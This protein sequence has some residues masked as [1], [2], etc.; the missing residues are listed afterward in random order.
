[1][2]RRASLSITMAGIAVVTLTLI[3]IF[4]GSTS[5]EPSQ[6]WQVL[7]GSHEAPA[8]VARIVIDIR[9]VK[10]ITALLAGAAL[11]VSG[12]E[13]QTLFRNPLAGPYVLGVSAGASLGV[14]LMML[15]GS[16]LGLSFIL[17]VAAA[18]WI[19]AAAVLLLIAMASRRVNDIMVILVL[20]MMFSSGV[21][22]VVEILQYLSHNEALKSYVVWTM[23]S[24]SDVTFP[25]LG[26]LAPAIIIGLLLGFQAVKALNL[27][28]LGETYA[29]TMGLNLRR[30]R[31]IIFS[32][33][34]L[35]AGTVTAYC[36][37]IGFIG[38]A[39]PHVSRML[40][41]TSDHRVLLPATML[42]SAATLSACDLIARQ[43]MLP[44]N[45]IT[46]LIGIPVVAWIVLRNRLN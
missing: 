1:M 7:T 18:A 37:P 26:V 2:T 30:A 43:W 38:L 20:G 15:G 23:G 10:A 13:M 29:S 4:T 27:L 41:G 11:G 6:V 33:T 9:L 39:M 32:S 36:G 45:A 16:V 12:L 35:L 28:L 8:R 17:P 44:I 3:H 31:Q 21:S 24:L 42:V 25:Q 5:L 40:T 19:G 46:S 22:A 34:I 14:A